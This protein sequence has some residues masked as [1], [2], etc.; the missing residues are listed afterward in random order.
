MA[1]LDDQGVPWM[2]SP[3]RSDGER[4]PLGIP[5]GYGEHTHAVLTEAGYTEDEIATLE[6][7]NIIK[8]Q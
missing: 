7:G 2:R 4:G 1:G 6:A 3:V 8:Q 5:P